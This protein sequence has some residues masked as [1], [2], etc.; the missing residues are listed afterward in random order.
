MTEDRSFP[1]FDEAIDWGSSGVRHQP[2]LPRRFLVFTALAVLVPVALV[3][4][5]IVATILTPGILNM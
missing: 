5:G 2:I 4:L 3:V 1:L